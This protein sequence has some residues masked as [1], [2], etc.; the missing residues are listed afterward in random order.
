[1]FARNLSHLLFPLSSGSAAPATRGI[2]SS[3]LRCSPRFVD[4]LESTNIKRQLSP[5]HQN[6]KLV[7]KLRH[8]ATETPVKPAEDTPAQSVKF[9]GKSARRAEKE[10]EEGEEKSGAQRL[11]EEPYSPTILEFIEKERLGN[12]PKKKVGKLTAPQDDPNMPEDYD[13]AAMQVWESS[14]VPWIFANFLLGVPPLEIRLE[15]FVCGGSD[16]G[17]VSA[18]AVGQGGGLCGEV[19]CGQV[20]ADQLADAGRAGQ[21]G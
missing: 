8:G 4:L 1:M 15:V 18:T 21:G 5:R 7:R 11:R 2:C 14:S 19:Q 3:T 16:T 6:Q 17:A 20:L 12:L 13:A 10:A 9:T